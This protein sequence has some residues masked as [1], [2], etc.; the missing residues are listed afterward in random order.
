MNSVRQP[1][2][3]PQM[4]AAATS[5]RV[6][7]QLAASWIHSVF[8]QFYRDFLNLTWSAKAAFETRDYAASVASAKKRLGLYNAT[9]YALAWDLRAAFP[10]LAQRESL[11]AQVEAAF[12][13]AVEGRYE[14][15]LALAYVHST[16]RRVHHGE[17]TPV[18]YGFGDQRSAADSGS[19]VYERFACTWPVD[20]RVIQRILEVAELSVPFRAPAADA[21]RIA[22]R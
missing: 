19:A 18:E 5:E 1:A 6:R 10:A 22:R 21:M 15:D 12:L 3:Y 2:D 7:V 14:A 16:R 20:H 9:V 17:W 8:Y 13:P 4:L 11:W